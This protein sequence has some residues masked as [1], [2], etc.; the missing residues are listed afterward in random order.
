MSE[1]TFGFICGVFAVTAAALVASTAVILATRPKSRYT[2]PLDQPDIRLTT[3]RSE[4]MRIN[5]HD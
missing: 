4:Y 2:E 1:F 3:I 5:D